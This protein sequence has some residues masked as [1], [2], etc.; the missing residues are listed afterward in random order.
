MDG[1]TTVLNGFASPDVEQQV[2][3]GASDLHQGQHVFSIVNDGNA[4]GSSAFLDIDFLVWESEVLDGTTMKR[5]DNSRARF[6]Y[7]PS[8]TTWGDLEDPSTSFNATL[9]T[10]IDSTAQAR[11][12]F[13]GEAAAIYGTLGPSHGNYTCSTDGG[14]AFLYSGTYPSTVTQQMLCFAGSLTPGNH[15]IVISNVPT[16]T[17]LAAL[18]IDYAEVWASSNGTTPETGGIPA[19]TQR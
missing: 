13:V 6:T 8:L 17:T 5:F 19:V 12:D 11:F 2:L 16:N 18:T 14:A 7:L 1:D 15:S 9:S 4:D 10:A 3:F